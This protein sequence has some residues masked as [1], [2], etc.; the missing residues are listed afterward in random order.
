MENRTEKQKA[1]R[2]SMIRGMK[3]AVEITLAHECRLSPEV[4]DCRDEIAHD[5][6]KAIERRRGLD[7]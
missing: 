6:E 2:R 5:I 4:C 1:V 3:A 7:N